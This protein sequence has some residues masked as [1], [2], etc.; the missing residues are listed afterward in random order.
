MVSIDKAYVVVDK[1]TDYD[2]QYSSIGAG[3]QGEAYGA[4]VIFLT[5]KRADVYCRQKNMDFFVGM[6]LNGWYET[7]DCTNTISDE[8]STLLEPYGIKHV[9]GEKGS[10]WVF[11]KSD[12]RDDYPTYAIKIVDVEVPDEILNKVFDLINLKRFEVQ[13]VPVS[14]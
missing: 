12:E 10:W 7:A 9:K 2:D 4:E 11:S 5:K 14:E 8:A 13:E 6:D 1:G 3:S